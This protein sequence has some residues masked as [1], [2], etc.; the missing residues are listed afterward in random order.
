MAEIES[1]IGQDAEGLQSQIEEQRQLIARLRTELTRSAQEV[2]QQ[3]TQE[4]EQHAAERRRA[5]HEIAER[6]RKREKRS[7][8]ARRPRGQ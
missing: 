4:L 6:M 3:A 5:L 7:E 1:R 8:G 2:T